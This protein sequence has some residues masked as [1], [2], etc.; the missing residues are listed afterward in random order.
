MRIVFD[1]FVLRLLFGALFLVSACWTSDS[2]FDNSSSWAKLQISPNTLGSMPY[3][4]IRVSIY[5]HSDNKVIGKKQH[6]K[7]YYY[8]PITLLDHES[9]ISTFNKV[10]QRPEMRFRVEMW[11]QKLEN[12]VIAYLNEFV[13]ETIKHSQVQ[14]LPLEKVVLANS[15]PSPVYSVSTKWLPYQFNKHQWFSLSCFEEKDCDLLAANMRSHPEQFEHLKL[16]FSLSSQKS[17]TKQSTVHLENIASGQMVAKLLQKFETEE[18]VLLT[19]ADEKR[20]LTE[21]TMNVIVEIFDDTDVVSSTSELQIYNTLRNILVAS[22]LTLKKES[23]N[24]WNSVFWNDDN[25]RPDKISKTVNEIYL[26]LDKENQRKMTNSFKNDR[27]FEHD[28]GG[29]FLSLFSAES[30]IKIDV[31]SSGTNSEED[32][33]RLFTEAKEHVEWNGEKFVPKPLSLSRINLG[34]FRDNQS[35]HTRNIKVLYTTAVLS[36]PINFAYHNITVLDQIHDLQTTME[37][38]KV[39]LDGMYIFGLHWNI[40]LS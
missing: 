23:D 6:L 33:E 14:V 27:K 11:N 24:L 20:L 22:R 34:K 18:E 2:D 31:S 21:T 19:A 28:V 3:G 8:T 39:Q 29:D 15:I 40:A 26:K 35:L 4:N 17:Q 25:Y 1:S 37:S 30:S 38:F 36:A 16:L 5:E 9:A 12:E 13:G 10:T 7:K 32:M